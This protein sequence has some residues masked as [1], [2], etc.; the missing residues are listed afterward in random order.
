MREK[1]STKETLM[2]EVLTYRFYKK[3]YKYKILSIR[4]ELGVD[5]YNKSQGTPIMETIEE[6]FRMM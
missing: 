4:G 5:I 2:K 6:K 1:N 3:N